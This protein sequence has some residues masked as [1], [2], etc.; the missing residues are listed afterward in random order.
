MRAITNDRK[1]VLSYFVITFLL[2]SAGM[3]SAQFIVGPNVNMSRFGG[4]HTQAAIAINPTN[5]KEL[6]VAS[7]RGTR[8]GLFTAVS[9]DG[10]ETWNCVERTVFDLNCAIADGGEGDP[11]PAACCDASVAWDEFGNL[12]MAYRDNDFQN[13]PH[14][15]VA[16]STDGGAT[17]RSVVTLGRSTDQPTIT[18]GPSGIKTTKPPDTVWV[19]YKEF[20][21]AGAPIVIHGAAVRDLG[22]VR[23]F[24]AAR[25]VPGTTGGNFGDI[26]VGPKGQVLVTY[27]VPFQAT[28]PA[29][30]FVN[31]DPDGLGPMEFSPAI[32]ATPTNVVVEHIPAQPDRGVDA[33]A[34]LAYDRTA[35]VNSGRVYLVYTGEE[36]AGSG[37]T[38]IFVRFSRDDGTTWSEPVRVN[39][40]PTGSQFLP[41]IALDQTTGHVAVSWHDTRFNGNCA[42]GQPCVQT[43]MV[44]ATVSL[45]GG[46]SFLPNVLVS[47]GSSDE[48]RADPPEDPCCQDMDYGGY[49]G[50]AFF[51]GNFFPAWADN[52]NSTGDNPDGMSRFDIYTA[53]VRLG[54]RSIRTC[55]GVPATIVGTEGNNTLNHS[56]PKQNMTLGHP[57]V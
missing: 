33:E 52:S 12:F 2:L 15:I 31:L 30:I 38:D 19:S 22:E 6:F 53:K 10:G 23:A 51:D 29:T 28:G 50:L 35:G 57:K 8:P 54:A 55:F 26:A 11:L 47:T 56:C 37:G 36:L 43:T 46:V 20:G 7:N 16:L 14:V 21:M 13:G 4:N 32:A 9:K 25:M 45:D 18:T 17:F 44:F 39:D 34:G 48:H 49:T 1:R 27:Q 42:S 3:A 5:P 41:R 40:D 24:S